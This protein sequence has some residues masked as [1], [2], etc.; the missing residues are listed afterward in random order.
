MNRFD[1]NAAAQSLLSTL[2]KVFTYRGRATRMEFWTFVITTG[3]LNILLLVIAGGLS[4]IHEVIG[5]SFL[6]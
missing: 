2:K 5:I 3:I 6:S 1:F 4:A